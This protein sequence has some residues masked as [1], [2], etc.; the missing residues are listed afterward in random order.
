VFNDGKVDVVVGLQLSLGAIN[1]VMQQR[2]GMGETGEIYLVGQ[3]KLMKEPNLV[4]GQVTGLSFRISKSWVFG[5][6]KNLRC[7]KYI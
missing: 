4:V 5:T 1:C 7:T 3:D 6:L 2:D